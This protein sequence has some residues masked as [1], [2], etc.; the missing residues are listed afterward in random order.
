MA[1]EKNILWFQV[2]IDY[3]LIV[4]LLDSDKD[5]GQVESRILESQAELLI[6]LEKELATWTKLEQ[7]VQ[8]LLI[9]H[10]I[11]KVNEETTMSLILSYRDFLENRF[12]ILYM[13]NVF[14][15]P[16]LVLFDL[17]ERE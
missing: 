12:L 2:P 13:L 16:Y 7:E 9:L 5:L 10:S 15:A 3:V 4:K 17:L 6:D 1:I 11:D 8:I 14:V